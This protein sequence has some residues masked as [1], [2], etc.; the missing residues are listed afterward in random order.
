MF[1][2]EYSAIPKLTGT[3][4]AGSTVSCMLYL[5]CLQREW[6]FLTRSKRLCL[7]YACCLTLTSIFYFVYGETKYSVN[8]YPQRYFSSSRT[9]IVKKS[10]KQT[11]NFEFKAPK[12]CI[13]RMLRV[14][15]ARIW[16]TDYCVQLTIFF[17]GRYLFK[18][19]KSH[20]RMHIYVHIYVCKLYVIINVFCIVRM[21]FQSIRR[22]LLQMR[23]I[24]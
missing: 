21:S 7:E 17:P 2:V 14:F 18:K 23:C 10:A 20:I 11:T 16:I 19:L 5:K 6:L 3:P 13:I 24:V 15:Y 4:A 9:S 12:S 8:R 1:R 22:F